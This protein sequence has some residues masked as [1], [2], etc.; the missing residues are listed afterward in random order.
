MSRPSRSRAQ[1]RRAFIVQETLRRQVSELLGSEVLAIHAVSGGCISDAYRCQL[2]NK[3]EVFVKHNRD[4]D[5]ALFA[6][7]AQGLAWLAQANA[8]PIPKVLGHGD[9]F[10]ALEYV[11][12][13]TP[14]ADF[15]EQLGRGL[16]KLHRFGAATFGWTQ[17]NFLA[18]LSQ[19]NY[20][21]YRWSTFYSERRLR[22]L[23]RLAIDKGLVPPNWSNRFEA[24]FTRMHQ[25][26]GSTEPP[27]RL[28]GDLWSG[29][30]HRTQQGAP[31]LIDPAV[32]GGHREVD[33]AMLSLFGSQSPRFYAAYDELWP[34]SN[35]YQ[36]RVS[37][38]Q[39]YPLL[40]HV[41]LFG[42]SYVS[43]CE[44]ALACWC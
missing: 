29:N 34:R 31:M 35:G 41:N 21:E 40:A 20:S 5:A 7:E 15:D 38:Y 42:G 9:D 1:E 6:T 30:L 3:R 17:D 11:E 13:G 26:V 28:H 32:Y 36:E 25:L 27:S 10:L 44:Q 4:C 14:A 23:L 8:L 24:L 22:P 2:A 19:D 33:L 39:L 43:S 12:P 18:T 16:A 37:L